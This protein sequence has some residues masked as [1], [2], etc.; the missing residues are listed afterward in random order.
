MKST[1]KT[2]GLIIILS[3]ISFISCIKK[4]ADPP[5]VT[6][7]PVTEISYKTALSGW[8]VLTQLE[9]EELTSFL[10][11][12]MEAEG[13]LKESG[14]LHW[15]SPLI[16]ATNESG[17]FALPGAD[18]GKDGTFQSNGLSCK[19]WTSDEL[20]ETNSL[21]WSLSGKDNNVSSANTDKSN[22]LS[23]RCIKDNQSLKLCGIFV[24]L[25]NPSPLQRLVESL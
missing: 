13:K 2:P 1:L 25:K 21:Y 20:N 14:T 3:L 15:L 6:T 24:R 18:R 16:F 10:G 7:I 4:P 11:G 19:F 12:T 8:H 22:G 17:F 5:V 23:V 9:S